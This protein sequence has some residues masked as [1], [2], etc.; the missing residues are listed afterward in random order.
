MQVGF[1]GAVTEELPSLVSPGG[2]ADIEVARRSSQSVNTEAATLVAG[3]A[4]LVVMLVHEGAPVDGLRH[5][6]RLRHVGRHRQQ[7]R[8][9]T[10]T[11]SSRATRTWRTTARSRSQEW[12]DEGRAV[13][14]RPVVSAGQYGTNLNQLVYTVDGATGEVSAK[15]Q[16]APPAR[17]PVVRAVHGAR[18]GGRPDRRRSRR[19]QA[20]RARRGRRSARSPARSTARRLLNAAGT[21]P[22]TAAASRR[23]ATSSPRCS[24]GRPRRPSPAPRRS[25]S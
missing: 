5:D 25:R 4:D 19:P 3:G 12:V 10:S 2:I 22:R 17:R 8:R 6:G 13:T 21:R 1:V 15:T 14:D 9:P 7:R 23:S 18:P 11:R 24:S 20:R 16:D